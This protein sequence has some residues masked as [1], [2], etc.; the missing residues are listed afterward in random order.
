[1]TINPMTYPN[2][3]LEALGGISSKQEP[4]RNT[5]GQFEPSI[6]GSCGQKL[7]DHDSACEVLMAINS[8]VRFHY[9]EEF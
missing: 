7:T 8:G 1:M 3:M 2:M 9:I 4:E 5:L 6:C